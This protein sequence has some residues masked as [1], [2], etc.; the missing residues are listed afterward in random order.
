MIIYMFL[1]QFNGCFILYL[2][3]KSLNRFFKGM[4]GYGDLFNSIKIKFIN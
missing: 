3:F 1:G 4:L 2:D